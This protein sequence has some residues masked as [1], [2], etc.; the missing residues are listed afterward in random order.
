MSLENEIESLKLSRSYRDF[1]SR[2][3]KLKRNSLGSFAARVGS[4]RGFPSEVISGKRRLTNK[5]APQF[6][7]GLKLPKVAVDFFKIL[8]SIEEA[9]VF[10]EIDRSTIVARLEKLKKKSWSRSIQP[11]SDLESEN[12]IEEASR[13]PHF[14]PLIAL[15]GGREVGAKGNDLAL[16]LGIEAKHVQFLL[17][18]LVQANLVELK[19]GLYFCSGEH[20][21]LQTVTD[22]LRLAAIF[23]SEAIRAIQKVPQADSEKDFFF[24][25][26]FTVKPES[27]PQLKQALKKLIIEFVD[28]S[29]DNDS[30]NLA[31]LVCGFYST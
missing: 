1:L 28:E 7:K 14:L 16:S 17:S 12:L 31:K 4:S 26:S 19:N 9:D 11:V 6:A 3:L 30:S 13:D 8:V 24:C 22:N 2:Y 15:L 20:L 23:K 5:S 18:K 27:M 29:I 21:N 10:P 25:S